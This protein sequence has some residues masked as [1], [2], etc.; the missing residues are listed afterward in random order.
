MVIAVDALE[1][2]AL[3]DRAA[4]VQAEALKVAVY[5]AQGTSLGDT[6]AGLSAVLLRQMAEALL[7]QVQA[8][9]GD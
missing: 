5:L 8:D 3:V 9:M 7:A 1:R 4:E 6:S 2:R